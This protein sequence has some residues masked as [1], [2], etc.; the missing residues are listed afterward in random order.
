MDIDENRFGS[1]MHN[2]RG[3]GCE[4][5][6][7]HH[8]LVSPPDSEGL[9][10]HLQRGGSPSSLDRLLGTRVG[11]HAAELCYHDNTGQYWD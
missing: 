7:R 10:G 2:H 5:H 4:R 6:G 3:R 1:H 11:V 8:D 9:Q